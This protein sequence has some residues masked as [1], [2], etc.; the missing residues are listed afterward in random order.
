VSTLRARKDHVHIGGRRGGRWRWRRQAHLNTLMAH[1]LHTGAPVF[2][3]APISPSVFKEGRDV[4]LVPARC[5]TGGDRWFDQPISLGRRFLPVR[6][7]RPACRKPGKILGKHASP[8]PQ[9]SVEDKIS[10]CTP[11]APQT[12]LPR[13][14]KHRVDAAER[15]EVAPERS[16]PTAQPPQQGAYQRQG[17]AGGRAW[18]P[19][20]AQLGPGRTPRERPQ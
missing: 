11:A 10:L 20:R 16:R 15:R 12:N 5:A 13:R 17:A 4:S 2:S 7:E 14:V 6:L 8:L 9:G 3:A 19:H 18:Q 1:E